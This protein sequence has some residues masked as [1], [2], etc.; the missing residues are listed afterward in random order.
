MLEIL[1][2]GDV[3]FDVVDYLR[4]PPPRDVLERI[5]D[6]IDGPPSDLVRVKQSVQGEQPLFQADSTRASVIEFLI[7]NP[8]LLQRP[9]VLRG[10]KAI[11]ARPIDRV[12]ELL[13]SDDEA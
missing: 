13:R 5:A 1:R 2:A 8:S 11:I 6:G 9:I 4:T 10:K 3:E 12:W 7:E